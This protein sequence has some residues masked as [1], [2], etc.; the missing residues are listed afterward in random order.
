ME[1]RK[2][3]SIQFAMNASMTLEQIADVRVLCQLPEFVP[4][5]KFP[6]SRTV[7]GLVAKSDN[8]E[9]KWHA[10]NLGIVFNICEVVVSDAQAADFKS[11]FLGPILEMLIGTIKETQ[12]PLAG[13][14]E[15]GFRLCIFVPLN[16]VSASLNFW[17]PP[18][19]ISMRSP[20]PYCIQTL[21]GEP[22][23]EAHQRLDVYLHLNQNFSISPL[24]EIRSVELQAATELSQ[25]LD[26]M[27]VKKWK[28]LA[29]PEPMEL[30]GFS[31]APKSVPETESTLSN[32]NFIHYRPPPVSNFP[33]EL[34][35][36][37]QQS[38]IGRN[39][40]GKKGNQEPKQ[41]GMTWARGQEQCSLCEI[42]NHKIVDCHRF[43]CKFC[44][45]N[46]PG[47][48]M[49]DCQVKGQIK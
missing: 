28:D 10:Y 19:N 33:N 17:K 34:F 18:A 40:K 45:T 25:K 13:I 43:Y 49:N 2:E 22:L 48:V 46:A 42:Q 23:S 38:Q 29:S 24:P 20:G 3:A 26:A 4:K 30:T 39:E 11:T 44:K 31:P 32:S 6:E 9:A 36:R 7:L 16:S 15:I 27:T 5:R 1:E 37:P 41:R 35:N 12:L 14:N 47:H 21:L 8:E